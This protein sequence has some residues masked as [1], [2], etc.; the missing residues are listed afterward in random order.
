MPTRKELETRTPENVM[1]AMFRGTMMMQSAGL[2]DEQGRMIA[3]YVTGKE[4]AE[5][6]PVETV[7]K[8]TAAPPP[9]AIGAGDWNGWGFDSDNSHF[10]T[11]PGLS[12][13]DVPKLK[14]KWAFGF[15]KDVQANAQPTVVGGTV[16]C[17][18]QRGHRVF[19]ER[20]DGLLVLVV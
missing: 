13:A 18:Q 12:A 4:F 8:C 9:L 19:A 10:Q 2:T 6:K 1:N 3:K 7:G 17:R 20:V 5:V 14:L 16:I 11:K 15:P